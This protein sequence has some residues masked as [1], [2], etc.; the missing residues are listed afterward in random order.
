MLTHQRVF[1]AVL[2]FAMDWIGA[3]TYPAHGENSSLFDENAPV[4]LCSG[5]LLVLENHGIPMPDTSSQPGSTPPSRPTQRL[6]FPV[7][8]DPPPPAETF[9]GNAAVL[10]CGCIY[11]SHYDDWALSTLLPDDGS[12][13]A[14]VKALRHCG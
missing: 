5:T 7:D 12:E 6:L 14:K 2:P 3:G 4:A 10:P 11:G 13:P 1:A 8:P 9:Q